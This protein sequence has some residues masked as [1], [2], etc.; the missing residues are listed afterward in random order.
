MALAL[1]DFPWD[2]LRPLAARAR[3]HVDGIVDLSVGSPVDAT[4]QVIRDALVAATDA[5]AYPATVGTPALREAI[6]AWFARR[7]GVPGLG[8]EHVLP[9]IGSKEFIAGLPF[10]LGLGPGDVVVHPATAYPTY[11]IGALAVGATPLASDN[12][13]EWPEATKLVWLNSPGNPDGRVLGVDELRAAVARARELGALIIG[14][15]CYAELGWTGSGRTA[16]PLHPRSRGR[17]RFGRRRARRVLAQQAV[18]PRGVP[19]R[20][21]RG[22]PRRARRPAR[23]AQ[24]P[25]PAAAGPRA[26]RH[27]GRAPG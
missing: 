21:R 8:A 11:A 5:H 20:V 19:R 14:D 10:Q 7:R 25:R 22:R 18:Q 24:A 12:P 16:R 15:E 27:D 23:G 1:P 3:E 2:T 6:A 26:A 13:A 9:T 4:P 17:R